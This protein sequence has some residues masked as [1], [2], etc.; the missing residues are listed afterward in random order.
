MELSTFLSLLVGF[1]KHS[2]PGMQPVKTLVQQPEPGAAPAQRLTDMRSNAGV[3]SSQ[4][5][6]FISQTRAEHC[7]LRSLCVC[8]HSQKETNSSGK[9]KQ[10]TD[11]FKCC[12]QTTG[13]KSDFSP[14][15][16][17]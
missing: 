3:K 13:Q 10:K 4:V 1:A 8:L 11:V 14:D 5:N 7:D 2:E 17:P 12:Q 6:N 16:D 9:K 15:Q